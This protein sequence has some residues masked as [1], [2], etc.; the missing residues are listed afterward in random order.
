[1]AKDFS[2]TPVLANP[3]SP[4]ILVDEALSFER[5]NGTIRITLAAARMVDG[6]PPSP[7]QLVVIGRL[8]MGMDSAERLAVGLFDYLKKQKDM[9]SLPG[10]QGAPETKPN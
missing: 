5:I 1:M 8:I 9:A 10:E 7:V 3:F 6:V 2:G 4:D